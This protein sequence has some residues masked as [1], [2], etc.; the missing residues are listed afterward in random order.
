MRTITSLSLSLCPPHPTM[1]R[2]FGTTLKRSA[3][4]TSNT[5]MCEHHEEEGRESRFL[6]A[7]SACYLTASCERKIA[8]TSNAVASI[9]LLDSSSWA[10]FQPHHL[11]LSLHQNDN[12]YI[13]LLLF[14]SLSSLFWSIISSS[15]STKLY[16]CIHLNIHV[17]LCV[18]VCVFFDRLT[19]VLGMLTTQSG[20]HQA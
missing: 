13:V 6:V 4:I 2:C 7:T 17:N 19:C 8:D 5:C 20:H 1:K 12:R 10:S 15:P 9:S 14:L 11:I 16:K 3:A 18:H